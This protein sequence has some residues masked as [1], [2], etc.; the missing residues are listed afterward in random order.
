MIYVTLVNP[1]P[2]IS[3]ALVTLLKDSDDIEITGVY[4]TLDDLI[5]NPPKQPVHVALTMVYSV[6]EKIINNTKLFLQHFPKAKMLILSMFNDEKFILHSIKA[7]AK[8][9]LGSDANRSEI[10]EAIYSLR[11]GYEFYAKSITDILLHSYLSDQKIG[12]VEKES[13]LKQLSPREL[14]VFKLFAEGMSN[15]HIAEKL[16]ISVRTVETHKN[17]IMKKIELKTTV[18]LV[19][20]AIKNN[21]IQID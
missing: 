3:D 18:D 12:P 4:E 14:E 20:F 6:S 16:F 5:K 1:F 15:R 8:G 19:K 21:I 9:H 13:K 7:G 17:N 11:N 10:L 2:V